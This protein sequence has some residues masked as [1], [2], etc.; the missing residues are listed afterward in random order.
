MMT[1]D[2]REHRGN[3]E[4]ALAAAAEIG[5]QRNYNAEQIVE[6]ADKIEAFLSKAEDRESKLRA[7]EWE[8]RDLTGHK[9]RAERYVARVEEWLA[10]VSKNGNRHRRAAAHDLR[11]SLVLYRP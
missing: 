4:I 11:G 7:R 8:F 5:A 3:A 1:Y 9:I 2:Y 10:D 6:A